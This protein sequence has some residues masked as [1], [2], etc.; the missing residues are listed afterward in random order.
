MTRFYAV[1]EFENGKNVENTN[2]PLD[3]IRVEEGQDK[4]EVLA[5]LGLEGNTYGYGLRDI[6]ET[7]E[8]EL[9]ELTAQQMRFN[10][11]QHKLADYIMREA[12][13]E[14]LGVIKNFDAYSREQVGYVGSPF[15]QEVRDILGLDKI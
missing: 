4:F 8:L 12:F 15:E 3:Y 6:T 9:L 2:G 11:M 7:A 10:R 13:N 5:Q 14:L 1:F